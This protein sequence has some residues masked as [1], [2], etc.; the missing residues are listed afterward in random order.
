MGQ[1]VQ[2]GGLNGKWMWPWQTP[3]GTDCIM[4]CTPW[5]WTLQ[6]DG[7]Q[8]VTPD[9]FFPVFN[10]LNNSYFSVI[11]V[12]KAHTNIFFI[13]EIEEKVILVCHFL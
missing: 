2:L 10:F 11:L 1:S 9:K 7:L 4:E 6:R 8:Y 12:S 13:I 5:G 3:W